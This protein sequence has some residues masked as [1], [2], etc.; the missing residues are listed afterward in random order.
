M[1]FSTVSAS[2]AANNPV[3][4]NTAPPI[5]AP[6]STSNAQSASRGTGSQ[7]PNS[8]QKR[9]VTKAPWFTRTQRGVWH[10]IKKSKRI[11]HK[12]KKIAI[13][14]HAIHKAWLHFEAFW[15]R[16]WWAEIL[17]Y[18]LATVSFA[19][20]IITLRIHQGMPLPE[21]QFGITINALIAVFLVL[22]KAGLFVLLEEGM[23]P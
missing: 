21:W 11:W 4:N 20:I 22:L 13:V 17:S 19:A 8:R 14:W 2:M 16:W 12:F 6:S 15:D 23:N 10:E 18:G 3:S 1:S 5:N 9:P 7:Y